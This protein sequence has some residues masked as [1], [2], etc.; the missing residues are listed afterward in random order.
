MAKN[1]YISRWFDESLYVGT[2]LQ[3]Q[4]F[5]EERKKTTKWSAKTHIIKK[6][7]RIK[8]GRAKYGIYRKKKK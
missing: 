5:F 6:I 1:R 3:M 4:K 7:P 8:G 2:K